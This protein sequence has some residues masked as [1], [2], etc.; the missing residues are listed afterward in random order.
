[1]ARTL[2]NRANT[3][4]FT[5]AAKDTDLRQLSQFYLMS[6]IE[7]PEL[8]LPPP[9]RRMMQSM[10]RIRADQTISDSQREVSECMRRVGFEHQM[11]VSPF[12]ISEEL[13]SF[14]VDDYLAIDFANVER[15]IAIEFNGPSHYLHDGSENGTTIAKRRLLKALGWRT[16]TINYWRWQKELN[17]ESNLR[18]KLNAAL[19]P[20]N[21]NEAG[22]IIVSMDALM[23]A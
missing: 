1:M 6:K 5:D 7:A 16:G 2:W 8:N 15:R 13:R 23:N 20:N 22:D 9:N 10:T 21:N 12:V 18:L 11:E 3:P 19:A 14:A 4:G 17:H